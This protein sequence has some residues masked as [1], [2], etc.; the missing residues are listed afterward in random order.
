MQS[1]DSSVGSSSYDLM[2]AAPAIANGGGASSTAAG[3]MGLRTGYIPV[4]EE[5]KALQEWATQY[6]DEI[7]REQSFA[8]KQMQHLIGKYN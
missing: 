6:R 1:P 7:A 4:T 3:A 2:M 5:Y 8:K